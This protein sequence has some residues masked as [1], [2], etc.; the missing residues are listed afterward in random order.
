MNGI[1]FKR[2]ILF[3]LVVFSLSAYAQKEFA[4]TSN[5]VNK[6]GQKEGLWIQ[7]NKNFI[8]YEYYHGGKHNGLFYRVRK[9]NNSLVWLGELVKD[10]YTGKFL[11][12][13]DYG[14]LITEM[15]DFQANSYSIPDI[16]NAKGVCRFRCICTNF[17]PNGTK[18]SEGILLFDDSPENDCFEYGEWKYFDES[19][20]QTKTKVF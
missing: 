17:Y 3:A 1:N 13:S 9:S 19:G 14:H 7:D 16:H 18:K 2:I 15:K 8:D 10:S 11:M 4:N 5:Q 6:Q 12:F 20:Q